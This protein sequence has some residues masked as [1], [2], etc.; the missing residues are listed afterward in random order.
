VLPLAM[1][2]NAKLTVRPRPGFNAGFAASWGRALR[3]RGGMLGVIIDARGR[4]L[5]MPKTAEARQK[6]MNQWFW[7]MGGI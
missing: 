1:G 2:A 6:L 3:V 4:P 5:A 7:K